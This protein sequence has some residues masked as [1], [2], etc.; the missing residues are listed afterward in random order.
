MKILVADD[1]PLDRSVLRLALEKWDYEIVECEDGDQALEA[2]TADEAPALAILDWMMPGFS[3]PEVCTQV[4]AHACQRYI[5]ILLL[6]SKNEK[7]DVVEGM[8]AGADDYI[9]KPV[10]IHELQVRLRAGRRI[11]ELQEELIAARERLRDQATRDFLTGAWNRA[12]I[13]EHAEAEIAR[14]Q[15]ENEL[16]GFVMADIDRFKIINDT[17]GHPSGDAV[18]K[19]VLKRISES[20]RP[21]DRVGRFGG[22]EFLIIV[23]GSDSEGTATVAERIRCA[24]EATPVE[25]PHG[26]VPV[27]LSL[28][29]FA[30]R[31]DEDAKFENLIAE[32][33]RALYLA[34]NAGRNRVEI[35]EPVDAG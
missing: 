11:I 33:D 12:A 26:F 1:N 4:R 22:E 17:H 6:T 7:D 5:Y 31:M 14:A 10:N 32:A 15:R 2:L 13:V 24:V 30:A 21:Y 34:K 9:A 16:L 25:A 28:G 35:A 3:G 8:E 23:P 20:I 27:T 19:E 18:L 29:V